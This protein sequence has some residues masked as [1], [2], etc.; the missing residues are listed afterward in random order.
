MLAD[1]PIFHIVSNET[2][3]SNIEKPSQTAVACSSV[4][5]LASRVLSGTLVPRER[6]LGQQV[7]RNGGME[8]LEL[9]LRKVQQR[10]NGRRASHSLP[11]RLRSVLST[12]FTDMIQW[13]AHPGGRRHGKYDRHWGF[14]WDSHNLTRR[15][16]FA[17]I[18]HAL[19]NPNPAGRSFLFVAGDLLPAYKR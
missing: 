15:S 19:N 12:A 1:S 16:F 9:V 7:L 2:A 17:Q 4:P 8:T 10:Q 18:A 14:Q 13:T 5:S 3:F 11:T 6:T